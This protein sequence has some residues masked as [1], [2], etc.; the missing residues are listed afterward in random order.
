MQRTS[1]SSPKA[2]Q[3]VSDCLTRELRRLSNKSR[4]KQD[5]AEGRSAT[6]E[7]QQCW[8]LLA[9]PGKG[10][11]LSAYP[12]HGNPGHSESPRCCPGVS[13]RSAL[14]P[15]GLCCSQICSRSWPSCLISAPWHQEPMRAPTHPAFLGTQLD[16]TS[17]NTPLWE[18]KYECCP[19]LS[20]VALA[21]RGK[22][23]KCPCE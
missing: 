7:L 21:Q 10:T 1:G 17:Q 8:L 12:L 9:H 19:V 5:T 22:Q 18:G 6:A 16:T 4:E 13:P 23:L 14:P 15:P 2:K 11:F 20:C 3:A